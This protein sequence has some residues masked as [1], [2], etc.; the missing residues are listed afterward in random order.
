MPEQ[1]SPDYIE[2]LQQVLSQLNHEKIEEAVNLLKEAQQTEKTIFVC[3][4][5]GSAAIASE[6]A[7]DLNHGAS[8]ELDIPF[9]AVSLTDNMSLVTALANDEGYEHVFTKQL[10]NFAEPEDILVA[11]SG[12]G[13]SKNVL[14]A[15]SYMKKV[16][17]KVIGLTSSEQGELKNMVDSPLLVPE[18]HMG[19]LEDTFY[20]LTHILTYIFIDKTGQ[21]LEKN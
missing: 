5:G 18:T 14:H 8:R 7:S 13:N 12:S 1:F 9:K 10:R 6:F 4:N 3:G 20:I 11:I 16:G 19:R 21:L 2:K 17:G 15:V